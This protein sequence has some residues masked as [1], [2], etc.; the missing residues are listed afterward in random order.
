MKNQKL[1][2]ADLKVKSFTTTQEEKNA[3]TVK[4][5]AAAIGSYWNCSYYNCTY[6][7][8]GC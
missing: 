3:A 4:G 6:Y 8:G 7:W 5:G 1:Q 2:I